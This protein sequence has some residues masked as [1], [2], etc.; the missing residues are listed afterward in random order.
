MDGYDVPLERFI[1][2][3]S[4]IILE[5]PDVLERF[6]SVA[7]SKVIYTR[8][9]IEAALDDLHVRW[10]FIHQLSLGYPLLADIDYVLEEGYD[11]PL[12]DEFTDVMSLYWYYKKQGIRSNVADTLADCGLTPLRLC[13]LMHKEE[14]LK[15][16][17]IG[18]HA[19]TTI[20]QLISRIMNTPV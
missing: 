11:G 15:L 4:K 19:L 16:P 2:E 17:G 6:I 7:G 3:L 9:L 20:L 14:L 5:D 1:E 10:A 13:Q 8:S 18:P 12:D